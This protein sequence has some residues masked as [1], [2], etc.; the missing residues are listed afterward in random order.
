MSRQGWSETLVTA[1]AAGAAV[2]TNGAD[3]ELLPTAA[4]FVLP[5]NWS[6]L[7][8][9]L[10]IRAAGQISNIVTTPGTL[11]LKLWLGPT[12]NINVFASQALALNIVAKTNVSWWLDM[13]VTVRSIGSGTAATVITQGLFT[14]ESLVIPVAGWIAGN[15]SSMNLPASA[16]AVGTGY[17]STVSNTVDLTANFSLTGN[18]ITLM[19]YSL[20]AMN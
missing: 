20:E 13:N 19:Q 14:S 18:S 16:P 4:R 8:R 3:T 15:P 6:D 17:D 9:M 2:T 10:R 11:T 5:A 7:G 12:A 1:E